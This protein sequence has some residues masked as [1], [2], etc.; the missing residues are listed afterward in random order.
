MVRAFVTATV[1][2]FALTAQA[3]L[4][5]EQVAGS[6]QVRATFSFDRRGEYKFTDLWLRIDRAGTTVF[7]EAVDI[8]TCQEPYCVP[9]GAL[10]DSDTVRVRDLDADGEPEVL[11]DVFTGGAHCCFATEILRFDGSSYRARSR[12]WEDSGYRLADLD[13]DGRPEFS[14]SDARFADVFAS[15]AE[16]AFPIRVLAWSKGRFTNVTRQHTAL[17]RTD[18]K[19][20]KRAYHKRRNGNRSLGVLAA[21][22]ADQY[23]LGRRKQANRFLA[24]EQRAGRLR[25]A[26]GWKSG[27]AFARQL[28]HRLRR[29]GYQPAPVGRA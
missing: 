2:A 12:N 17:I 29:W 14:T 6:G 23:L 4:A 13:D 11:V 21:W 25:S 20:W 7:D 18:A 16:S 15:F 26:P 5:D 9:A 27:A 8:P 19:R 1:A 10:E 22:T 28:K 24:H 3:A